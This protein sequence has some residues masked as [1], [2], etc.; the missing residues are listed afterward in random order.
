[1]TTATT[2]SDLQ[3]SILE[4]IALQ[5]AEVIA[6]F[7]RRIL[8]GE[9]SVDGGLSANDGFLQFLADA[10]GRRIRRAGSPELTAYGCALLAGH[11]GAAPASGAI[12]V[13]HVSDERRRSW[14]ASYA[15][16]VARALP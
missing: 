10:S 11:R 7:D 14:Q 8:L 9:L 13:P 12:F 1:M 15:R 16:A 4:G 2:R 5:T 3:R 6:T